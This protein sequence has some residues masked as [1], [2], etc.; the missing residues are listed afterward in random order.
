MTA[1]QMVEEWIAKGINYSNIDV[2]S[3]TGSNYTPFLPAVF[4]PHR[5]NIPIKTKHKA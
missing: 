2:A 5:K 3:L 1:A 4:D